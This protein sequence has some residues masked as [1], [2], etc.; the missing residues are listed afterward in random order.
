MSEQDRAET[1][2]QIQER[3]RQELEKIKAEKAAD[4]NK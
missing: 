2:E 4:K 1:A 3:A